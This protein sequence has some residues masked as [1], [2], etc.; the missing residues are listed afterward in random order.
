M[1]FIIIKLSDDFSM[2]KGETL[3]ITL[4]PSS[5]VTR[6]ISLEQKHGTFSTIFHR[7][8]SQPKK[9]VSDVAI[10]RNIL[11]NEKARILH[12]IK[13]KKPA[14]IY[15]LAKLL[16]RD[17]KAVRKD[18]TTLEHFGIV[19]LVKTA[20]KGSK[21]KSLAPVL[22]LDTLQININFE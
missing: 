20:K 21:R 7:F 18:I 9:E 13:T 22:N 8:R 11:S 12:V 10:L 14:S 3:T 19:K 4:F 5:G 1:A 15:E 17:F 16:G 2:K 6:T